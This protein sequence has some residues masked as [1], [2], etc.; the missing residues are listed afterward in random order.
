MHLIYAVVAIMLVGLFSMEMSRSIRHAE[1]KMVLNEVLTQLSGAGYDVLEFAGQFP[2]DENTDE[3]KQTPLQYPVITSVGELTALAD[4]GG[5]VGLV[6]TD[7]TCD[8]LDD[9]DDLQVVVDVDGFE[10]TVTI[11]VRYVNANNPDQVYVG[12]SFAKELA[13]TITNPY[14]LVGGQPLQVTVSRVFTY[15]R[16]IKAP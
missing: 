7:P 16:H 4:F 3:S 9:L 1:T 8:D 5:C 12:K 13:L 6:F 10:Y 14:L 15:N 11:D 2:F